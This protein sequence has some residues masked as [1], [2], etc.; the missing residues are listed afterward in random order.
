MFNTYDWSGCSL[1]EVDP[2]KMGG[3]PT[4][5]GIRITPEALVENFNNG[6]DPDELAEIYPG[7]PLPLIRSVLEYA[8][9]QGYLRRPVREPVPTLASQ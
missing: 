3:Q 5:A 6:Y 7:V 9:R 4:V 2:E 8:E 1:I